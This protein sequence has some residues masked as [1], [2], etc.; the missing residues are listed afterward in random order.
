[1]HVDETAIIRSAL[2][3]NPDAF[4]L[5]VERYQ[6]RL[7]RFVCNIVIDRHTAEEVAQDAN[8]WVYQFRDPQPGE[9]VVFRNP[10]KRRQHWIKRIVAVAGDTVAVKQGRIFVNDIE[11]TREADAG[12]SDVFWEGRAGK[13]YQVMIDDKAKNAAD[14]EPIKVPLGQCYVLGD[15]RGNSKDS[16]HVGFI[17]IG[18]IVG[19][20]QYIFFPA[21]TWSR[22]GRV[23]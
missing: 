9:L 22:F 8:K 5:L 21:E 18:D 10:E 7:Y 20:A 12:R 17:P 4:R 23:Q 6:E 1:M 19:V 14:V 3:G 11:I 15:N 16:R 13:A 2:D